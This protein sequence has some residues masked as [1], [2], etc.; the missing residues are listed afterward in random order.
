M[1]WS[2]RLYSHNY[3]DEEGS[4]SEIATPGAGVSTGPWAGR[5]PLEGSGR[6]HMNS[7]ESGVA[8]Q[9][10]KTKSVGQAMRS[11]RRAANELMAGH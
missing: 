1:D 10:V 11:A 8:R 9:S 6:V 3:Y 4:R 7:A 2:D 5:R